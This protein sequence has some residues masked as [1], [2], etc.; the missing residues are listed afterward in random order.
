[1]EEGATYLERGERT[2]SG[3][4]GGWRLERLAAGH[5]RKALALLLGV[6]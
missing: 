3:R 1:M 6:G 4:S 5:A 2:T